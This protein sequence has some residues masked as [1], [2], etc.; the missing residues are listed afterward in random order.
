MIIYAQFKR[1]TRENMERNK[2]D[3]NEFMKT[4]PHELAPEGGN[5]YGLCIAFANQDRGARKILLDF[6]YSP[7]TVACMTDDDVMGALLNDNDFATVVP[8]YE[9]RV[10]DGIVFLVPREILKRCLYLSR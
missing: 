5:K 3:M 9:D 6:G 1:R 8:S 2:F 7:E 10:D 4:K